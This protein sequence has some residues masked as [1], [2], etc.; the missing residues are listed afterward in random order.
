MLKCPFYPT[1]IINPCLTN[2][3]QFRCAGG[4]AISLAAYAHDAFRNTNELK[5][6]LRAVKDKIDY[7]I[8]PDIRKIKQLMV[9]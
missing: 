9:K 6:E 2:D 8:E 5:E 7:Y 4:C 1:T 3:C